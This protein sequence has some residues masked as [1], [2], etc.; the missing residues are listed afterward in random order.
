MPVRSRARRRIASASFD[1]RPREMA[2]SSFCPLPDIARQPARQP[3]R[4]RGSERSG[5]EGR[6]A[7]RVRKEKGSTPRYPGT[8]LQRRHRAIRGKNGNG[9][10]R[11]AQQRR[12]IEFHIRAGNVPFMRS[13]QG[14]TIR[15]KRRSMSPMMPAGMRRNR[16][17][18]IAD[19]HIRKVRQR[20]KHPAQGERPQKQQRNR[21]TEKMHREARSA[22]SCPH[23]G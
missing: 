7:Y 13:L 3:A 6:A 23:S 4:N 17:I 9:L 21:M 16:R 15:R 8:F 5:G 10:R 2:A 14:G 19:R 12:G 1:Q 18:G 20:R 22:C 11:N